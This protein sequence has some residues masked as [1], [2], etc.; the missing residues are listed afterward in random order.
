MMPHITLLQEAT[1]FR[2]S[3]THPVALG[4]ACVALMLTGPA[5]SRAQVTLPVGAEAQSRILEVSSALV[6]QQLGVRLSPAQPEELSVGGSL[7]GTLSDPAKLALLGIADA[8]AGA[9]VT[10]MRVAEQRLV[11]EADEIEPVARTRRVTLRLHP[12]GRLSL[13]TP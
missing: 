8:R 12:D 4:L 5:R 2:P 1:M 11:V 9:R 3:S 10:M 7:T 13:P 6:A